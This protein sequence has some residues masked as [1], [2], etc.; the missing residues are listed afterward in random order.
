MQFADGTILN[1]SDM[2]IAAKGT[3]GADSI[4]S[5]TPGN[6]TIS[7]TIYGYG[8]DDSL[9]GGNGDDRIYGG[10]GGDYI[11]GN[12][13][14]DSLFGEDGDDTVLGGQGNDELHGGAGNDIL[15]GEDGNDTLSGGSGN[16]TLN[17]GAGSDSYIYTSGADTIEANSYSD[18]GDKLFLPSGIGVNDVT[19]SRNVSDSQSLIITVGN[20]GTVTLKSQI[21]T[22]SNGVGKLIFSDLSEIDLH[23]L[24]NIV[25]RGT[26]GDDTLNGINNSAGQNDIL[27]G[28]A[29]NN[30]LNG[31]AGNDTYR[32][33]SGIDVIYDTSGTDTIILPE[34]VNASNI[35]VYSAGDDDLLID[36]TS[37]AVTGRIYVSGHR[38]SANNAIEFLKLADNTSISLTPV[39]AVNQIYGTRGSDYLDGDRN[40]TQNDTLNGMEGDDTLRGGLGNDTYY[41]SAGHDIIYDTGGNDTLILPA[42]V[43]AADVVISNVGTNDLL[44]VLKGAVGGSILLQDQRNTAVDHKIET[45]K[46][47]NGTVISL[48]TNSSPNEIYGTEKGETLNG[49]VSGVKDDIIYGL[50]GNDYIYGKEGLDTVYGG[51]GDDR[52]Y[53]GNG[54]DTLYGEDGNDFLYGEAGN[55]TLYGGQGNDTISGDAG[56]DTIYGDAGNDTISGNDGND[57]L[58]GGEGDDSLNGQAGDDVYVFGS[59]HDVVKDSGLAA[60]IDKIQFGAGVTLANLTFIRTLDATNDLTIADNLGNTMKITGQFST[61][62]TDRIE[63]LVFQG[64]TVDFTAIRI[65]TTGND[66]NNTLYGIKNGGASVNDILYGY[67]GND[68]IYAYDGDDTL[69][70][71]TGD[72][73]LS[74][75]LGNDTYIFAPGFQSDAIR[76]NPGEGTDTIKFTGG[77]LSQ[78]VQMWIADNNLYFRLADNPSDQLVVYGASGAQNGESDVTSRIERVVFDNGI[79]WDL[80]QGIISQGNLQNSS[81]LKGTPGSDTIT[82]S[83]GSET[84]YGGGGNDTITGEAGIDYMSGGAGDDTYVFA[85]GFTGVSFLKTGKYDSIIEEL[86]GGTDTILL[87]G[88]I[89]PED[90]QMW[91]DSGMF[92]IQVDDNPNNTIGIYGGN[93]G[94]ETTISSYIE[95]IAFDNGVVWDTAQGLRLTDTHES[96]TV[97]GSQGNDIIDGRGGD[98]TLYGGRGNDILTGGAGLDTMIGGLGDDTYVFA[99]GFAVADSDW[100]YERIVE[101]VGQGVDTIKFTGGITPDDVYGWMDYYGAFCLR[102]KDNAINQLRI[103]NTIDGTTGSDIA[104]RIE[105]IVFDNGVIWDLTQGLVLNDNDASHYFRG[106]AAGDVFYGNGGDDTIFGYAGN[107]ILVGGDGNDTIYGG[108]GNDLIDGGAGTNSLYGE[109]GDDT[110]KLAAVSSNTI[111]DTLG[112]NNLVLAINSGDAYTRVNGNSLEI[113][114]LDRTFKATITNYTSFTDALFSNGI[115]LNLNQLLALRYAG[116]YFDDVLNASAETTGV[117]TNLLTGNDSFIGSEYNDTVSGGDGIDTISYK[118][119]G[120]AVTV[121]LAVTTAQ[122]TGGAGTDTITGFENLIGSAYDDTLTG[123]ANDNV[124]EG[125]A[126]NDILSGGAGIDTLSY[127]GASSAVQVNLAN[128]ASQFTG[129]AGYDTVSGFENLTGSNYNDTLTGDVNDNVID[130]GNGNDTIDGGAGNDTLIGGAGTDTLTYSSAAS[131]V[132]VNLGI[133]TAQN[134]GGSGK[135]TIS[136]FENLTGSAYN[137]TLTGNAGANTINGGNGNDI[138]FGDAGNDVLYGGAGDDVIHGGSGNDTIRGDTGID[139]AVFTG[140]YSNYVITNK[141]S[142]L[143]VSDTIGTDGVDNVY[144]DVEKLRF[145]DGTYQNGVFTPG[146][147]NAVPVLAINGGA[148]NEDASLVVTSSMLNAT[149]TDNTAAQLVFTVTTL[150]AHGALKNGGVALA[151]GGTFTMQNIIDGLVS[152][153]P[154]ANYNG[155]DSF[156]FSLSDGTNTLTGKTFAITINAVND[157]PVAANDTASTNE[158]TPV[159]IN[160]L[161]NDSDIDGDTLSVGT[162]GA[163]AHGT[164]V[165]NANNTLTYTPAANYN[166]SDSFTYQ[167]SDGKGGTASATVNVTITAVND[168]PVAKNDAFTGNANTAI[169]GNLLSDNGNGADSDVDGDTLSVTAGTKVTSQGGSVVITANGGFTY[170]P[171]ANFTGIDSFTYTLGDGKGGTATGTATLTITSP[172]IN[173][174]SGN[175]TL[176]GTAGN[177]TINGLGGNDTIDGKAGNDI[178]DGG[179]GT[180]TVS[181]ASATSGVTV[182]LATTT[183]QNTGGSGMDTILNFENLKGSAY[184]DIL[185]GNS[186]ANRIEGGAGNDVIDGGAGNDVLIGGAG[187]DRLSYASATA[188]VTVNLGTT[189]AQNT[190]GSGTDT[191]SGFEDL[192]GSAYNDTLTGNS[193]NNVIEGGAGNDKLNGGAGNDTLSYANATAGI[194]V[195][196]GITAAQNTGGAGTDTISNF[197]NILGSAYNDKLTGDSGNNIIEGGAGNDII[198]GAGGTDTASYASA[199]SGVTV[200]LAVTG[201][202][203]TGGA[204][205]D[206]ITNTENLTGSAFGDR[207]TGNSA[208]NTLRGNGGND[209]LYGGSGNDTLYGGDGDDVLYGGLG[210]DKLYG[211]AGADTFVFEAASAYNNVDVVYGFSKEQGDRLDLSDLLSAYDPLSHSIT[212]FVRITTS[213]T[214]SLLYVDR[215]GSGT[216]YGF[217]Q[218]AT[219]SGVTG[220]TDE[221]ALMA[222]GNLIVS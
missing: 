132:S 27:E 170:T 161:S 222:G 86:N 178:M 158:D 12:A 155:T 124:I 130:G 33:T 148:G 114:S 25:T 78:N 141:T 103:E 167:I 18:T 69:I 174:T 71:G 140:N 111:N 182:N 200:S 93:S 176:N 109:A 8:G 214:N 24:Q 194:T 118:G 205:T 3:E 58:S 77:I 26:A 172:V 76:E 19:F 137:D 46:L 135:D 187:T 98:D 149:D 133:T 110:Y 41:A 122:N 72:D 31:G 66:S 10:T 94:T 136:G 48:A 202:Q 99:P 117:N 35:K 64:E 68:S 121:S 213:D 9:S 184:N 120:S 201:A 30:T 52:I 61:S 168:A 131:G 119:A 150:P 195:S 206:T 116:T 171:A 112:A 39:N 138:I 23:T 83:S 91:T 96:H 47:Y 142:Y 67:G 90:V 151:A 29:G 34:G 20:L 134:T 123:D 45:L 11:G 128:A 60:D 189:S 28:G 173:G 179:A 125:G 181:Y 211:D 164:V 127:S 106:T 4:G 143:T 190:G 55:D 53:G 219:L 105:K 157:A 188:A 101:N 115:K 145:A 70:G 204:G 13:G 159:T 1:I 215:D 207:L 17:G 196:L 100:R 57:I 81:T 16:D 113:G 84:I 217:T 50:G 14:N 216:A 218:I 212:E 107:D 97:Y 203:N 79:V 209:I 139:T 183:A 54:N 220:L 126:G 44:I 180:D 75:G 40:G 152:F 6:V 80:T 166:G 153:N 73:N 163:A 102:L 7:D 177:D 85:P 154:A 221:D 175:D 95:R 87:T 59:G 43:T 5:Y 156:G 49:D 144:S 129:S 32:Y 2:I 208:A 160:V 193:G 89:L 198:D 56:N 165:K 210:L 63:K 186:G 62:L 191:I 185:T 147:Q 92:Y 21:D 169:T 82:G 162:V 51:R 15:K 65:E 36:I 108:E 197:E 22:G 199:A 42:G 74:G 38:G 104:Q 192:T 146:A 88:G 37:S